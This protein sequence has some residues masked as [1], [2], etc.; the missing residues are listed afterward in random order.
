M[1]H[2]RGADYCQKR[3]KDCGHPPRSQA[4]IDA[5]R[6][7]RLCRLCRLVLTSN[8]DGVCTFRSEAEDRMLAE[9]RR[10]SA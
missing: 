6:G 4:H 7:P 9:E 8:P 5:C 3:C 10:R 2:I 1:P